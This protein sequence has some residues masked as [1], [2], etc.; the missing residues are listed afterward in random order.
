MSSP[1]E[2]RLNSISLKPSPLHELSGVPFGEDARQPEP[3]LVGVADREELPRG[4]DEQIRD[5][6]VFSQ[7]EGPEVG[8][9]RVGRAVRQQAPDPDR[10]GALEG[11]VDGP[12]SGVEAERQAS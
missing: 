5:A 11:A 9:I 4:V 2:I 6:H 8:E 7:G 10:I 1:P 3:F 12:R